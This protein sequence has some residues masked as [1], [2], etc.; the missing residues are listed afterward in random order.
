MNKRLLYRDHLAQW[1]I[2]FAV[3]TVSLVFIW[4]LS[5]LIRG[6]ISHISWSFLTESPRDAGR[7]GGIGPILISTLWI[8][9]V[10]LLAAL[11][12]AWTTAILLAEFVS[13]SNRF[14]L[15]VSF[16]LQVL[17]G[18][19]SIVFGL[20]GNAFFSIYLGMGFSILSGGLTLACMLLPILVST[21][22]AGLRAV[23][24]S[25]RLSAAALGMS[26]TASLIHL[27]LPAAAPALAAGLL[28]GIG[29]AIA[30]TAALIFTSG[31]VDRMPGSLLDSGRALALHIFDL[32]MNVPGGDQPAYASA[33]VLVTL[34]LCINVLAMKLAYGLQRK[35]IMPA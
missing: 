8:F 18:V 20:F 4:I 34:L 23:P 10:A 30:E 35:R 7:S 6:G 16:S 22:E 33:L 15:A 12:L 21:A 13:S 24:Q 1:L 31:Y 26:R 27:L 11:P 3:L 29:R 28:L 9:L 19:P 32:S 25:Y 5:D 2:Y 14:G 17:A